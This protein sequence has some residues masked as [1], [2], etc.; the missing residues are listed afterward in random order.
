MAKKATLS[1][2]EEYKKQ[3]SEHQSP[4][5]AKP[6]KAHKKPANKKEAETKVAA[7][8]AAHKEEKATAPL[9]EEKEAHHIPRGQRADFLKTTITISA[10]MLTELRALGMRRK[11]AKQKDTDTSALI[12]EALTDFLKKH[13][14]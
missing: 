7:P 1:K 8:S 9:L 2:M 4:P 6:K 11:S 12:R 14:I 5:K 10:E 3:L 13:R